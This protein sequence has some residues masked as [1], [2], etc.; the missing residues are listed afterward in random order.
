MKGLSVQQAPTLRKVRHACWM[1]SRRAAGDGDRNAPIRAGP[2]SPKPSGETARQPP[3]RFGSTAAQHESPQVN[4]IP[5]LHSSHCLPVPRHGCS[6]R[7]T[8]GLTC[9]LHHWQV[10]SGA[11]G[12]QRPHVPAITAGSTRPAEAWSSQRAT[13]QLPSPEPVH[14]C[15]SPRFGPCATRHHLLA[16]SPTTKRY[17]HSRTP[18]TTPFHSR[19]A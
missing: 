17:V 2:A 15:P 9:G 18:P 12:G 11:Q 8:A 13:T 16:V 19:I 3:R 14:P 5:P 1:A 10:C 4:V 7:P 6:R